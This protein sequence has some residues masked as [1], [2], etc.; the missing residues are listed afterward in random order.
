VVAGVIVFGA[1]LPW[2]FVGFVS[3]V[4]RLTPVQLQGRAYSAAAT[5]VT[6]PQTISIAAGAALISVTGYRPMLAAMAAVVGLAAAYL[7]S[8]PENR[9]CPSHKGL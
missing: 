1:A 6:T 7:L 5:V 2:M 3:L 4:Q 9:P 8:R